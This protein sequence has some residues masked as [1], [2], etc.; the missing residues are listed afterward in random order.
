MAWT[1]VFLSLLTSCK[2]AT[3]QPTLTQPASQSG[4]PGGTIKLSCAI[5]SNP[6]TIG[7]IQQRSGEA[8]HFVH[9]DGCSSRGE[10]IPDRF[11][12]TRSGNNGY[13]T[14]TNLQAGDE[15]DYYCHMWYSS[16][17]VFHSAMSKFTLT[18]EPYISASPGEAAKLSCN[19]SSGKYF[20]V[21][22]QPTL[23]QAVSYSASPG[24]TIKLSCAISS[25]PTTIGWFQ[26]RSGEAPR[27]VHYDGSSSRG[28]GIPDR[29]TGTRSGNNGYLTISNLQAEDEADYYCFMWYSHTSHSQTI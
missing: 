21:T 3:S 10:G 9:C 13:L 20:D 2:G 26:Q 15:A 6:Y 25:N 24:L 29:F 28:P 17:N 16:G 12:A 18:Q 22:S 1:L 19:I 23:T 4:S 27:F 8:P 11:T 7:W 5:S 14:I